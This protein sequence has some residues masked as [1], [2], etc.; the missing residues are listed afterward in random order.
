MFIC[1]YFTEEKLPKTTRLVQG[2][3]N[4]QKIL[5][6]LTYVASLYGEQVVLLQY[7]PCVVDLVCISRSCF[8]NPFPNHKFMSLPNS[9]SL[10][11]T[12]SNLMKMAESSSNGSKTLREKEKLLFTSNFSFSLSVFKRL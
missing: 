7:I 8:F 12:F 2:D 6:C 4:A 1:T 9:K 3:R 10:Q 11:T 5:E